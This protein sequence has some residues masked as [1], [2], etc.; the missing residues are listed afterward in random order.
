MPNTQ[1]ITCTVKVSGDG[2]TILRC[3]I[4]RRELTIAGEVEAREHA[5]HYYKFA[6]SHR[7]C[8]K[9]YDAYHCAD[10]AVQEA[11]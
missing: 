6:D 11:V 5:K 9:I 4:C 8:G 2:E 10:I 7:H 3:F 1:H